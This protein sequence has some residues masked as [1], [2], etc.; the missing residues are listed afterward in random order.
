MALADDLQSI[1]TLAAAFAVPGER[2]TGILAVEPHEGERVYLCAFE[3]GESRT[4]LALDGDGTPLTDARAVRAAVELAALCEVAEEAAGGGDLDELIRRLGEIRAA[5]APEGIEAAEAA[6]AALAAELEREP[7]L[8]TPGY[9]DRLGAASRRLEQALGDE[10]GSPFAVAVQQARGAVE[11]LT[12]EVE[13][14]Y[15]GPLA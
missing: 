13:Q 15:K 8:A 5:D 4:W 1:A 12:A 10:S 9:L 7:R 2:V 11:E 6:A 3:S 14:T